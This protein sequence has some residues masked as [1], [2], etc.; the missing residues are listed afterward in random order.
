[1]TV[2]P[3]SLSA[4]Q[5]LDREFF[6]LRS[7]LLDIAATLDRLD[8]VTAATQETAV[9]ELEKVK[10][11]SQRVETAIHMLLEQGN[12]DRVERIQTL[13]SRDYDSNWHANWLANN[14]E[15]IATDMK[16]DSPTQKSMKA[17]K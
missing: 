10:E 12:A 4:E 7:R 1:M 3:S 9:S 6:P 14:R 16:S 2:T 8:R 13:F 17:K 5:T 15:Q 11:Q